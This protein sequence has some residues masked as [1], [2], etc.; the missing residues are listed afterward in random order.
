M[1][2]NPV[3]FLF[4]RYELYVGDEVLDANGQYAALQDLQGKY[5]PH[6]QKARDEGTFDSVIMRPR[7]SNIDGNVVLTWSVGHLIGERVAARYDEDRDVLALTY[8][9]DDSVRYADFIAIPEI[10]ALAIDDRSG[11]LRLGGKPAAN[12]FRSVFRQLREAHA[13]IVLATDK[14]DLDR[15]LQLWRITDFMFTVRPHNPHAPDAISRRMGERLKAR[16]VQRESGKWEAEEGQGIQPDNEMKAI[17][18]LSEAGY[19]QVAIK[20]VTPDGHTAQIK[21]PQFHFDAEKN[22]AAQEKPRQMRVYIEAEGE[23]EEQL[24]AA[25]AKAL[26][27]FYGR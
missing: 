2:T 11:E 16:N 5:Y 1:A 21:K 26:I 7:R 17:L 12:R 24:F 14:R 13:N 3:P 15:A 22:I 23:D 4:C 8:Q 19:G 18:G 25:T 9:P 20:G 6:G 10:G 27:G